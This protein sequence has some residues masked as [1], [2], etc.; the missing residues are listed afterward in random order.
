MAD[1]H[2]STAVSTGRSALQRRRRSGAPSPQARARAQP[3]RQRVKGDQSPPRAGR[4]RAPGH[5]RAREGPSGPQAWRPRARPSRA[6]STRSARTTHLTD[7]TARPAIGAHGQPRQGGPVTVRQRRQQRCRA[8]PARR[9]SHRPGWRRRGSGRCSRW[10]QGPMA[11]RARPAPDPRRGCPPHG[12]WR[13]CP[14]RWPPRPPRP[15]TTA[16]RFL[17]VPG[18]WWTVAWSGP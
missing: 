10:R 15:L 2:Q 4:R 8:P 17:G 6:P 3:T 13:G 16:R 18:L 7:E 1:A 14:T 9:P 12:R 5:R 11:H